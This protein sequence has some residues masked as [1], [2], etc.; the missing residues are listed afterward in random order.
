MI[1]PF[2]ISHCKPETNELSSI[3]PPAHHPALF[4]IQSGMTVPPSPASC[5]VGG[6]IIIPFGASK[7]KFFTE[8]SS[9][10]HPSNI[11][12][13]PDKKEFMNNW[14]ITTTKMHQQI[15]LTLKAKE[16]HKLDFS[17]IAKKL[18]DNKIKKKI[19]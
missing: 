5:S 6:I 2:D 19:I 7:N 16:H 18:K 3:N 17:Q 15:E 8:E 9:E 1:I 14:I 10:Y 11:N 13:F 4:L 12:K